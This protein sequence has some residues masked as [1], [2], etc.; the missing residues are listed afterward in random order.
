MSV[1]LFLLLLTT[2]SN[3]SSKS[4]EKSN[5]RGDGKEAKSGNDDSAGF[6]AK[7]TRKLFQQHRVKMLGGPHTINA[8]PIVF[9]DPRTGVN[10][11]LNSVIHSTRDYP[12]LYRLRLQI[13][14]SLRGS[15]RHKILF[16]YPHIGHSNFGLILDGEWERDLEARYFGLGNDSINED[17]L[18]N[19]KNQLFIDEDF[20]LYNLKRPR[21]TLYGTREIISNISLW[22]G[23]GVESVDPQIK[24]DPAT[25][26]LATDRPFG[27]LGGSGRHFSLRLRWDTRINDVFPLGGFLTE[28][29]YEPNFASLKEEVAGANGFQRR[30]RGVTF[31]RYTFS[32]A[33][34][35]PLTSSNRLIFA[36]RMAFDAIAGDPPFY[37]LGEIAG[38]PYT[39]ALGG[40]HSLRGFQ[41]RRF[42]DKIK[43][44]TLTELRYNCK[45]FHLTGQTFDLIFVGFFDTGRVWPRWS[46]ISFDDF[47]STAGLG[48]WLNW[49]HNLIIRFDVGRSTEEIIPFFRLNSAF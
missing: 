37:A 29:S 6:F 47:H 38:E 7:A 46:E 33:H 32:D 30:S 10:F 17:A 8:L 20:Y 44:F 22:F 42:H 26:F 4:N 15:H 21:I 35:I 45:T 40:S 31:Q 12:Y 2:V 48:V 36:N 9:Y 24:N 28:I 11:G 41:S 43:F 34:F 23:F 27:H 14:A 1:V 3:S 25:S 49:N 16:E 18:T 19:P 5:R 39:R 13:I